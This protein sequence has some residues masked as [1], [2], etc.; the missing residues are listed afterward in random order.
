MPR[1]RMISDEA[2]LDAVLAL[3]HRVGRPASR[4]VRRASLVPDGPKVELTSQQLVV[5]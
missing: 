2:V 5:K 1:P 4:R 3:A